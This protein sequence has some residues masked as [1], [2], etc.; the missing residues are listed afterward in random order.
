MLHAA[1]KKLE[2]FLRRG[3]S[4]PLPCGGGYGI[5]RGMEEN[6]KKAEEKEQGGEPDA[7]RFVGLDEIDLERMNCIAAETGRFVER[8][9]KTLLIYEPETHLHVVSL[10][11]LQASGPTLAQGPATNTH[12]S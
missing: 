12:S 8:T 7:A 2:I 9:R 3:F 1:T 10:K 4:A 5:I 6:N 11:K